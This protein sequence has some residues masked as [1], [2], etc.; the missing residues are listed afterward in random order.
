MEMSNVTFDLLWREAVLELL[1][2][3]E[4]ENPEDPDLAPKDLTDWSSIYIKYVQIFSK[5]QDSYDQ[6]VHPQKRLDIKKALEACLGRMLEIRDWLTTLND[7]VDLVSFDSILVDLKLTPKSVEIPIPRYFVSEREKELG[8]RKKFMNALLDKYNVESSAD[9]AAEKLIPFPEEEAIKIIQANE[10]GRQGRQKTKLVEKLKRQ[11]AFDTEMQVSGRIIAP[12]EAAIKIQSVVRAHITRKKVKLMEEEE[13]IF[14]G[15]K[16]KPRDENENPVT[17]QV[18]NLER[19][20]NIQQENRVEYEKALI[21]L[22]ERIFETEGPDMKE[23]I[24]DKI[25]QWF[26]ETRNPENGEYNS[27]PEE[28]DGGSRMILTEA[29][30]QPEEPAEEAGKAEKKDDKK[31]GKKGDDK[32]GK[33]DGKG[34]EK[35]EDEHE[36]NEPKIPESKFVSAI[37]AGVKT[38]GDKWQE[39]DEGNNFFQKYDAEMV[40]DELRPVVYDEVRVEVD[41]EMRVLLENL[42]EMVEAEKAARS[43]KKGKK[44]KKD[45][46][47]K[48]K[49]KKDKKG[50]KGKGKKDLTADRSLESLYAELVEQGI[51]RPYEERKISEYIGEFNFLGS[52]LKQTDEIIRPSIGQTR[53]LVKEL[54]ILPLGSEYLHESSPFCKSVLFYGVKDSG[55]SLMT[56]IIA[57][58]VGANI[59]NISPRNT[60]GKYK[61]KESTLM[62]HMVFKVA[63][64]M[65]PSIILIE[66]S[67]KVFC[68]D[69][70]KQKEFA[71]EFEE[72]LDR[73]KKDLVK[74]MKTVKA[75][76]RLLVIGHTKE[77]QL[78]A[79]KDEKAF[80]G[81]WS[82]HIYLPLPD[83]ASLRELW[84]HK[85]AN[86]HI[87]L[88]PEFD[89]PSLTYISRGHTATAIEN[90]C[91]SIASSS[92]GKTVNEK[93]LT[94]SEIVTELSKFDTTESQQDHEL[95][96]WSFKLPSNP[97]KGR[98]VS[99]ASSKKK[100]GKKGKDKKKKK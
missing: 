21:A 30:M 48:G 45:K 73:I 11:Q 52:A 27:L 65:A 23:E 8:E 5:L 32:A 9:A 90:V 84:G 38:Y 15:M 2:V 57:N 63:R 44:G 82:K 92:R 37:E 74:E 6:M 47:K 79:K 67:E 51:V 76:E 58:S 42:R 29:E 89:L 50:K 93:P 59:F 4:T 43:G 35:G 18:K 28:E 41:K 20:R 60:D 78:C 46:K 83:Y 96:E 39:R 12:N 71:G 55:K 10:R 13:L 31:D 56:N 40:K 16:P 17:S 19:R 49:G 95:H 66:E 80:L 70:K 69:K 62:V 22:K 25:N 7:K 100:G 75:G 94:V 24:Q 88:K 14:I 99:T 98:S 53:E 72:K 86:E 85:F 34:D 3:L 97:N 1:E 87:P 54:C 64:A 77:P 26:V 36:D 68:S 61:G 33:K 81:F 91:K